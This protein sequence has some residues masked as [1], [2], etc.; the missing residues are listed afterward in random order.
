MKN[1]VVN[2]VK[3]KKLFEYKLSNFEVFIK[4]PLPDNVD[5][6]SS[7]KD[8]E[9]R[10][11]ESFLNLI[12][13]MYVGDFSFFE[14]R[15]INALYMDGAVYISNEQ[16]NDRDLKDDI[17]HELGHAVEQKYYEPL[18]EDQEIKNEY[19]GKIKK[20]KNYIIF[21]G[22][23]LKKVNFFNETYNKEFDD[24]LMNI[25]G[26]DKLGY[27]TKDLF[28]DVYSITSLSE[29]FAT[30]FEKYFFGNVIDLKAVCPYLY[31]K[32]NYLIE[33][34]EEKI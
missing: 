8:I 12:D 5:I 33:Q 23:P 24:Y 20:L 18:F 3:N 25:I 4:D 22:L 11:P 15:D 6:I 13:V 9:K 30:G 32:I 29:Y 16:D 34:L 1:E 27:F 17:I 2:Y 19:F 7:L 26:Y 28:L 31:K 21:E 10:L 14:K